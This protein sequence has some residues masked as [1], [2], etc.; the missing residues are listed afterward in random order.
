MVNIIMEKCAS[1]TVIEILHKEAKQ[2][3]VIDNKLIIR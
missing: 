3:H 2:Q 1:F